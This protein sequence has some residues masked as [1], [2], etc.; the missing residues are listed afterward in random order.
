MGRFTRP[1]G[2]FCRDRTT[3]GRDDQQRNWIDQADEFHYG[4]TRAI[5]V[6]KLQIRQVPGIGL[7]AL[8]GGFAADMFYC[9]AD[10]ESRTFADRLFK[11]SQ[12]AQVV[13]TRR[14]I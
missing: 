3:R 1:Q 10:A 7:A 12:Y 2:C 5:L 13:L 6:M 14:S 4:A 9:D 11:S 8:G